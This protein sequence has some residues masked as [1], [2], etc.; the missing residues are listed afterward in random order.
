MRNLPFLVAFLY[1]ACRT[2]AQSNDTVRLYK[3]ALNIIELYKMGNSKELL[4]IYKNSEGPRYKTE[5]SI[6]NEINYYRT[7]EIN[8]KTL[9]FDSVL[10]KQ[11]VEYIPKRDGYK[12]INVE[13]FY[14][15]FKFPTKNPDL[16]LKY[17]KFTIAYS[18]WWY[19]GQKE[20]QR[21]KLYFISIDSWDKHQW[22]K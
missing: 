4:R 19:V 9:I 10:V 12:A 5:P 1:L 6:I 15:E 13:E 2:H 14:F 20:P 17:Y 8:L 22:G 16:P 3:Q 18:K 21:F 11:K 7:N